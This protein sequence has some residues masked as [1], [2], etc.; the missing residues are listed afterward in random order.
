MKMKQ[1]VKLLGVYWLIN[2]LAII[3]AIYF[4]IEEF[5]LLI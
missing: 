5:G 4:V 1:F 3:A 2:I